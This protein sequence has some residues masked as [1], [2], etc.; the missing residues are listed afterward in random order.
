VTETGTY[1]DL[2]TD[3]RVSELVQFSAE[4]AWRLKET[5]C[6]K[7]D[8]ADIVP[9]IDFYKDGNLVL[10]LIPDNV[11]RD[12]ALA[13]AVFASVPVR[14]DVM[15]LSLDAHVTQTLVNPT[16]GK[17]WG[18]GEMQGLCDNEGACATGLLTDCIFT[19]AVFADGHTEQVQRRYTGHEKAGGLT[20]QEPDHM[21]EG[22]GTGHAEGLVTDV[23]RRAM[24]QAQA[25]DNP[26]TEAEKMADEKGV[27][28]DLSAEE[29]YWVGVISAAQMCVLTGA[30]SMCVFNPPTQEIRDRCERGMSPEVIQELREGPLGLVAMLLR[31]KYGLDDA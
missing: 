19:Q 12:K 5:M 3:V 26:M 21:V 24:E 28:T 20:W 11:S 10:T 23:V 8:H 22:S 14:P 15:A 29:K 6:A 9:L 30:A 27:G 7:S 16:T 25:E 1:T 2:P 18:P 17:P 13:C 4:S 31:M